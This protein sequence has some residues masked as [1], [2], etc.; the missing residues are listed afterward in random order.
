MPEPQ[1]TASCRCPKCGSNSHVRKTYSILLTLRDW[2]LVMAVAGIVLLAAGV[3]ELRGAAASLFIG[4]ACLPLCIIP[5]R[6][7]FCLRCSIE[8]SESEMSLVG[9]GKQ[10][11]K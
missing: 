2:P 5:L 7:G 10:A 11:L 9:A 1:N 8:F 6:K 4:I 3:F